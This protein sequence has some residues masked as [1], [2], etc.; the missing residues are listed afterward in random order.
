MLLLLFFSSNGQTTTAKFQKPLPDIERQQEV[1]SN[2]FVA[3]RLVLL[4]FSPTTTANVSLSFK[5]SAG[6]DSHLYFF[7]SRCH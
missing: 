2:L 4:L 3:E 7:Q 6:S 1:F 5:K